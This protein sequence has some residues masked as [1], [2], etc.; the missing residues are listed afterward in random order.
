MNSQESTENPLDFLSQL[1]AAEDETA[2]EWIVLQLTLKRLTPDLR[3]AVWA[4]AIPTGSMR[5]SW[6]P[7]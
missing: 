7:C 3:E 2:R 4:V 6:P 5:H 1:Q